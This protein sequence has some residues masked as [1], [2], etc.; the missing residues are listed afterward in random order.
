MKFIKPR[1]VVK[2]NEEEEKENE[3]EERRSQSS[4]Q[5]SKRD[6]MTTPVG[7]RKNIMKGQ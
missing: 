2:E 6:V 3:E 1:K 4:S 5:R 7:Q